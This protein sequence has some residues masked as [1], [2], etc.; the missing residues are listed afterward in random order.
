MNMLS[1][2]GRSQ[3]LTP[4]PGRLL[5]SWARATEAKTA[6]AAMKVFMLAVEFCCVGDVEWEELK[7]MRYGSTNSEG[8]FAVVEEEIGLRTLRE[9]CL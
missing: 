6:R 9:M 2:Q 3:S 5:R 4:H 1:K 7:S 8:G